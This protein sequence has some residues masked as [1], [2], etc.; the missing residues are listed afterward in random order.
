MEFAMKNKLFNAFVIA[1][2]LFQAVAPIGA[3]AYTG[4]DQNDYQPGSVVYISGDNSD[5][6]GFAAGEDVHVELTGPNAFAASCDATA[7]N[8]AAWVCQLTLSADAADGSYAYVA[9]GQT[10]GVSQTGG[11]TVTAPAAPTVEPTQEATQVPS[12]EPTTQSTEPP[13]VQP[14]DV[15]T[16]VP[17]SEPTQAPTSEPTSQPTLE[18]T[19]SPT[20]VVPAITP[21]ITSD[22]E[23]Y[24]PAEL[25]TLTSGNWQ[26]GEWVVVYVNDNIGQTWSVTTNK[27]ADVNGAFV[28][29]FNLPAWFVAT[30][31]VIA[32]GE[33]SGVT[34]VDFTDGNINTASLDIRLSNC[35]TSQT[36]FNQGSTICAHST[37]N[38]S[39]GGNTSYRIKW[40]APGVS[41]TSGNPTRDTAFS[42]N[43]NGTFPRD[44]SLVTS[45]SSLTGS[46]TVVICASGGSGSC[47]SNQQRAT[48]TFT[49]NP[50]TNL[51]LA[52]LNPSSVTYGS[53]GP[54]P[55]NA[56]LKRTDTGSFIVGATIS[57]LVDSV[58]VGT[59]TTN[60]NGVASLSYDPS[61][62][63]ATNHSVQATFAGATLGGVTYG[64]STSESLTLSVTQASSTTTVT[65]P[66][67]VTFTGAALAPC[68]V[69][70]SGAGGLN[71]AP[72]ATYSNNTNVGTATAS[73]AFTGDANHTGSSDSKTFAIGKASS[74]TTVTCPA[75]V[76]FDGTALTPC[77]VSVSG[78]GGLSLT[79]AP[80]YTNNTNAGTATASYTF[81]GD[82]NHDG[83]S[84]SRTFTISLASS[85]TTVT[86]PASVT[87]NGS[88]Q[89][90]CTVVVTG[91]GGLSLTP[92]PTYA[93]NT[94][95]GTAT[96]S[97]T[98]AG[99]ANH[100]GSSDSKTFSIAK[101]S[102]TVTVSCP[103]S[104]VYTGSAI[105]PCSAKATGVGMADLDVSTSLAYTNNLNVGTAT[106]NASWTGDANHTDSTGSTTFDITKAASTVTVACP[107]SQ[108]YTGSAIEPCTA[109][110]TGA[111]MTDVDVSASL[112]YSNN[113]NVGTATANASWT[114]DA[115]HSGSAG[116]ATFGITK[117][118]STVTV[119]CPA[120]KIY[121]GSAIEPCTASYAGAGGLT[122]SL[123]VS[124][125]NNVVVGTAT[126]SAAYAGDDNHFGSNG[127]ATFDI[128]KA[129]STVTVTCPSSQ[130]YTGAAIQPCTAEAT[131]PGM[132]PVDVSASLLYEE[133]V[134]VGV[135]TAN[136]SW[137]GDANH[138]GSN[139]SATFDITKAASVVTV[140]CPSS[141]V[142]IGSA[143]EPCTA[144]ATGS[145]MAPVDVSASLDYSDNVVV[146]TASANASWA[147]DANHT[148]SSGSKTFS[149][150]KASS[151]VTVSCPVSKVYT[152]SAIEPCTAEATG[153]GMVAVDVSASLTYADNVIVG[154]ATANASW[155]GDVNHS[156][157]TGSSTFGIT[158]AASTVIVNCPVSQVYTGSAIEPCTAKATGVGMTDVNVSA[159]LTYSGNVVVG[160]ATANAS[161]GGDDNHFGNN[162]TASFNITKAASAVTVS[163][164]ESQVYTG[165]EIKPCSATASGVGMVDVDVSAS[166][167]YTDNVNVG[168][169][170]AN[171]S[172]DGDA[173]H[174]GGNGTATFQIEKANTITTVTCAAGP[175]TYNGSAQTPCSASVTGAGGLNQTLTV[176]YTDNL[177]AGT[178]HASAS[179]AGDANHNV[180]ND[181]TTFIIE[182]ANAVIDVQG[183][184]G[185][186]DGAAHGATGTAVGVEATP[187]DLSSL[188]HL[189]ASFT[190]VPG[191]TAHWTFDGN[192]NYKAASGDVEI[193]L[194]KADAV[195]HV[196]GY[197]GV[198][199]GNA[200][201]ATG[202][203]VG[204]EASPAD[205]NGLLHLGD[206]FTN[207]P[208]G[209]AHWTFDGNNNYN[210]ASGNA[211]IA[212][213]K[214]DAVIH[215]EGH[216]GEYDGSP[217]AATGTAVGV[218]TTPADLNALLHLGASFTNVPGGKAHW[219]FD[220]NGNYN[221]ANGEIDITLSKAASTVTLT[222]PVSKIY[223]GSTIDPCTAK[224]AGVGMADVDVSDSL[225]YTGNTNVGTASANASWSGDNNHTGSTG[226][227]SF[228]IT[229]AA[230]FTALTCPDNV[231]Y[232]GSALTP[233][234]AAVT[235]AGN[236]SESLTV[237]Y[238]DN[239]NAGTATA[240]A[241][242]A[243]DA[244]HF[245]SS[246]SKDFTIDKVG[247]VTA[248][249]CQ[250][251]PFTFNGSAQT[252]CAVSVTGVGGLDLTP[253][254]VY[255]NNVNAG[256]AT[257]G[258][259]YAGDDNHT[260]SN[261]S[262]TFE[263]DKAD[264]LTEVTC[265][266][267]MT[268]TGSALTPCT[269]KVTGAGG[270]NATLTVSYTD[271]TN[272]GTAHASAG[273]EG[274]GNHIGSSDSKTFTIEKA[275]S[276]TVVSCPASVTYTASALTPC[277]VSVTG[278][279][280]LTLT[281][282]PVYAD[283]INAGTATASYRHPGDA[284]HFGSSNSKTFTINKAASATAVTCP[285]S[286]TYNGAAQTPCTAAVTGVGSLNQTIT[287]TYT[288][289]MNAG[290]ATASASYA[291]DANHNGSTATK[292]FTIDKAASATAVSC[293]VNVYFTG[294]ALT[295]CSAA[296]TGV[297]GLNQSLTVTYTNNTAVG[298]ATASASF[299]GDSNHTGSSDSKTFGISAWTLKGFYQPV[300]MSVSTLV[301]NTIKNGSTVPLKFE[302]FSG[303]AELID[304]AQVKSL[305]YAQTSCDATAVTDDIETLAT[306]NTV[307][308]YDATAGQFIY[309]W[310]TPS[311]AGK[312]YRVTMTTLDGST[313]VAYFKLK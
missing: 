191:G 160:T 4:T 84:S 49:L 266:A 27:Q 18:P 230:S 39:G 300:D 197:T 163:C 256:T 172:W 141:Q 194:T 88:A 5:G 200:H 30:Y 25:V 9:T 8:N 147:G 283:N 309:N 273:F 290:Q 100:A 241:S 129:A 295:P 118:A 298:T 78:A 65:C 195:I 267:N 134:V 196:N 236:L 277:T 75:S 299:A 143:I 101:A 142:Y 31:H 104:E 234:T 221:E 311:T 312:C 224:A 111:G 253:D 127:S 59:A 60:A 108:V 313:L 164:P 74:T 1:L 64:A 305:T 278:A 132:G 136:A 205:L 103:V 274:D 55:L 140:T 62:I 76:T 93:N 161:W 265:P 22:K 193:S 307:L 281:P 201:G 258:Y 216:T 215:V 203:A 57:F 233:C 275:A 188:L 306:G 171:A 243:G 209:T 180:S 156:P 20:E 92:A 48:A 268:Y 186:Y 213:T 198:Y 26:P 12:V 3:L 218:E 137:A 152:G 173:N 225:A 222:C 94:N 182:K 63:G 112:A 91:P 254:P 97:Y 207:V 120:S 170:T 130:V 302:I 105:E 131:G 211:E 217:H 242:Y 255:T 70:V 42:E 80:T 45:T 116:S 125:S 269:A 190:N 95:A 245:G 301:Y 220:G 67:G 168:T 53:T 179:F 294:S 151:T 202:T 223:T 296:V 138:D 126:A 51:T 61:A 240:S 157:S 227:A 178:A 29:Q 259:T 106:A 68:T 44:D 41:I 99:D 257:A 114:G 149:I 238:I 90:P 261:D 226:T 10:S 66:A 148:G 280:G 183:Y 286:V 304:V 166:L 229:K 260:G 72:P 206:T 2:I 81:V 187:A 23:D 7:N 249:I 119:S 210:P 117:A 293:P 159:S 11:F 133:N 13:T 54:V 292:N 214:A 122:G 235:G 73:Y 174:F 310:K 107:T 83:S 287:V 85:T 279:G 71:L 15:A 146:G 237:S 153:A 37:V 46:W 86:C 177:D 189:G 228:E 102:S 162:G 87:Y 270:L 50:V 154:T 291:G 98:F 109:K 175:F 289:N 113:V 208:G 47:P 231:T 14:T 21:F 16:E 155:D 252:P 56:A 96:A 248:V 150:T 185:D 124:Y 35:S 239:T 36:T 128:N 276:M 303:T 38:V 204:V 271:N 247:S 308:R 297:G 6:A 121:T 19:A 282:A 167:A 272:A 284:N 17:T 158:K 40:F 69:S 115:N 263:I 169:A 262:E 246:N 33:V 79:P 135:A 58:S 199:D 184:T 24:A 251:G 144:E 77:S 212:L 192:N 145:G 52:A 139:G 250:A 43:G 28:Y 219:T 181:A 34:T 285:A 110:A 176:L 32:T 123:P 82:A 232:A 244:N 288:N 165:S 264:S 89:T